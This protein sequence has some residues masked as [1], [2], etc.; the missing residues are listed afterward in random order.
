VGRVADDLSA[1][2]PESTL[3]ALKNR[4][5]DQ[6]PVVLDGRPHQVVSLV[7]ALLRQIYADSVRQM[8]EPPTEVRLTHPATWNRPR[9]NRLLEAAAKAELP[10]P[11]L[12][13]EPVAAALSFASEVGVPAGAHV[14]VY[15]LG[16]G[17]FDTAV[18]T[19]SG[20][21]FNIVGR[22]SGDQN[23]GGELFDEII[24]NHLGEQLPPDAWD[25]I[26]VGDEPLWQ[27][28][29]ATLRN[30]ARKAKET[31]SGNPYADLIVPLPTGLQQI[32]ITRSEF[33]DL[34]R[35]YLSETVTLLQRCVAEAGLTAGDLAGISLVGGSSRSPIVEEMVKHAFPTVPVIRRGDPKTAVAAGAARAVRSSINAAPATGGRATQEASAGTAAQSVRLAPPVSQPPLAP[36]SEATTAGPNVVPAAASTA[37]AAAGT[38]GQP[39]PEASRPVSN[40]AEPV[41]PGQR[42]IVTPSMSPTSFPPA[43]AAPSTGYNPNLTPGPPPVA[44]KSRSRK[45][46]VLVALLLVLVVAAVLVVVKRGNKAAAAQPTRKELAAALLPIRN[47]R[48]ALGTEWN[49]DDPGEGEPFCEQFTLEEPTRERNSLFYINET[50]DEVF[51]GTSFAE[52]ISSFPTREGAQ[53]AFD[54]D[55]AITANCESQE[56]ELDGVAVTYVITDATRDVSAV[57]DDVISV[58]YVASPT[59]GSGDPL[60]TGYVIVRKSGAIIMSTNYEVYYREMNDEEFDTYLDLTSTAFERVDE[61]L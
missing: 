39:P 46:L 20:G 22:P 33:E 52:G 59:D 11:A 19:A 25:A 7:A 51:T 13:P 56:S 43:V 40:T 17:T 28:V 2:H 61:M 29:G 31:L 26:Q 34:V 1:T 49:A 50:I 23:I 57:G 44:S 55:K 16:G 47:V 38:V 35:P 14:V 54:Q 48:D 60:V 27:Q 58:K 42:A 21:G 9:L 12:V 53:N 15:D 32:R 24:V 6:A 18:V 8:G 30:E 45:P 3:R 4:L 36:S 41:L 10:N 5:G 37:L